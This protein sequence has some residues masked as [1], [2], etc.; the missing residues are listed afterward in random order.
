MPHSDSW[1][2]K[3]NLEAS[4]LLLFFAVLLIL[5]ILYLRVIKN[6]RQQIK[7]TQE[8]LLVSFINSY[9][10]DEDFNAE[11]EISQ[12]KILHLKSRLEKKVTIKELLIYNENLKGES[13]ISINRLFLELGLDKLIFTDLKSLL[14]HRRARAVY[15][16][17]KLG[18][19][20]PQEV[21]FK[22][23]ND[24][25]AEVRQQALLYYIKNADEN[26]LDFLDNL[27]EPL[28]MWQQIYIQDALKYFYEGPIPD[29]SKWLQH[30]QYSVAVFSMKMMAEYNQFENIEKLV[31]FLDSSN[32]EL[33][34]EAIKSL[35]RLGYNDAIDLVVPYFETETKD[36]KKEIFEIIK[37]LG[38]YNQLQAL[39]HLAANDEGEIQLEYIK[40]EQYF[41]KH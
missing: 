2:L 19:K 7:S 3:F 16:L 31:P 37:Q 34:K 28:T 35:T 5:F 29:F 11:Y 33:K 23:L 40:A 4:L 15:V 13:T 9:L 18:I 39:S 27:Y 21:M 20:V 6:I 17:S 10:F 30:P 41:L 25:N 24:R 32:K 36:I 22:L 26:P 8:S 12:F 38:T 14:W 1:V